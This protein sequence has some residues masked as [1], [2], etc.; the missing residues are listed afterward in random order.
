[1]STLNTDVYDAFVSTGAED[2]KARQ[3]A[4]VIHSDAAETKGAIVK[5]GNQLE[6]LKLQ[7][8]NFKVQL[9]DFKTQV[10]EKFKHFE[11]KFDA[12]MEKINWMFGT[13][14][15]LSLGILTKLFL[16]P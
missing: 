9:A 8:D 1:M 15:V 4:V 16:Q 14:V 7:L 12:K 2:G 6:L 5:L 13:V 10:E 3:A 11:E